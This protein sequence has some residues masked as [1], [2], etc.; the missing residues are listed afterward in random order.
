MITVAELAGGTLVEISSIKYRLS[1]QSMLLMV[2]LLSTL[3]MDLGRKE[4][5]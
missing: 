5:V 3:K 4:L 1:A 2:L